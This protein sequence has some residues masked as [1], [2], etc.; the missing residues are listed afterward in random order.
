MRQIQNATRLR[1]SGGRLKGRVIQTMIMNGLRPTTDANRQAIFNILG[2]IV[3]DAVV[4]DLYA[5]TGALG[6][7][8]LSRGASTVAF[9]EVSDELCKLLEVNSTTLS[10]TD[11][12]E[13]QNSEIERLPL[14]FWKEERFDLVF[15]DP[16]YERYPVPSLN[17]I[18]ASLKNGGIFVYE[19]S[20]RSPV[21]ENV[22]GLTLL[23]LKKS[24]DT[25]IAFYRKG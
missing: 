8:A 9:A 6:F 23:K 5:G 25:T 14:S 20:S 21:L 7:E 3:E 4:A 19:F 1:L 2:D 16:P 18:A 22:S 15:A 24:G 12:V 10:V 11:F 13:I 17:L